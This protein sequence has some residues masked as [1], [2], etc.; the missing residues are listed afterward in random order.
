MKHTPDDAEHLLRS[1]FDA[2][3]D[4]PNDLRPLA[5]HP[6]GNSRRWMP[7]AA[8]AAVAVVVGGVVI[9]TGT[10]GRAPRAPGA[11][12]PTELPTATAVT[13]SGALTPD[14]RLWS[15]RGTVIQQG[16]DDIPQLC[17]VVRESLPPQCGS[18]IDLRGWDW[19]TV[20]HQTQGN[21]RWGE[22]D[23]VG[24]YDTALTVA[25]SPIVAVAPTRPTEQ[26][27]GT[28]SV[29]CPEP[30]GG[31][32]NVDPNKVSD[33][34]LEQAAATAAGL[35]AFGGIWVVDGQDADTKILT[36]AVSEGLAHAEQTLRRSWGG[37][38]C[39]TTARHTAAELQTIA[40]TLEQTYPSLD[41]LSI[42]TTA[43]RVEL[44]VVV[45]PDGAVQTDLDNRYGAGTVAV[46]SMLRP[47]G[48]TQTP[49]SAATVP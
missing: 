30:Q 29:P 46:E 35:P 39:V 22:Y 2:T 10:T 28:P 8:A 34:D 32:V 31:W 9:A 21:T 33:L 6:A 27:G 25:R 17:F 5:A 42:A 24:T 11:T 20:T 37:P 47:L 49:T 40:D 16:G 4:L 38:L 15:A 19:A 12:G 44:T 41:I 1:A 26:F 13:T 7:T 14:G 36:V 23:V 45:D 48:A 3:A 43:G 18:G